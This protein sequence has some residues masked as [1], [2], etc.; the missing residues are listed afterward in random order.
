MAVCIIKSRV[1]KQTVHIVSDA[2]LGDWCPDEAVH[3]K[4]NGKCSSRFWR[5]TQ[6]R[7]QWAS[8]V[9]RETVFMKG[10]S[11]NVSSEPPENDEARITRRRKWTANQEENNGENWKENNEEN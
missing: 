4:V 8:C 7:E 3:W 9:F 2:A 5:K 11:L 1:H 6:W 10:S